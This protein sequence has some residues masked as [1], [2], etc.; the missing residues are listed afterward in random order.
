MYDVLFFAL[1]LSVIVA[2]AL[3]L[4]LVL[5]KK[6]K[7][8]ISSTAILTVLF[9]ILPPAAFSSILV[10]IA[11][12]GVVLSHWWVQNETSKRSLLMRAPN[13]EA[14]S[15]Q[16]ESGEI[17]PFP[18]MPRTASDHD[19]AAQPPEDE[20]TFDRKVHPTKKAGSKRPRK[21]K[22]K[23]RND[24]KPE[25]ILSNADIPTADKPSIEEYLKPRSDFFD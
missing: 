11:G 2:Q 20:V 4:A 24:N 19:Q 6:A 9:L 22:N 13:R 7:A 16:D 10:A 3:V 1:A 23:A 25:T 21:K 15:D 8:W 5:R 17:T 14:E 18:V 12:L